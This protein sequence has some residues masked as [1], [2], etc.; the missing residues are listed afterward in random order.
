MSSTLASRWAAA[1]S[2][3]RASTSSVAESTAL[4]PICS[5]RDPPV[6]PPLGT[7]AVSDWTK[8]MSSSG[9]PSRSDTIMANAVAWP[10]P[11]ADVPTRMVAVPSRWISTE[12]NSLL[13]PPAV[14]STYTA[15]PMPEL[16]S[17]P[18][19]PPPGLLGSQLRRSRPGAPPRRGPSGSRRCRRSVPMTVCTGSTNAGS[20][21]RRRSSTGSICSSARG[22][23]DHPLQELGRLR[24]PGAPEGTHR[25]GVGH[26]HRDVVADGRDAVHPLGH[27]P[28]RTHGQR[29]SEAG[30]GAGVAQAPGSACPVMRPSASKPISIHCTW[31]R[32][33]GMATRFSER[34]STQARGRPSRPGG[35]DDGGVLV[36]HP[37][38]SAE[39]APDVRGDH[40][41]AACV[42][43]EGAADG[44]GEPVGH[45]GGHVDGQIVALAVVARN[46]GD[47]VA[48]HRHHRDPLVLQGGPH[49]GG[50]PG[51]R[52][53]LRRRRGCRRP[54][55]CRSPRTAAGRRRPRPAPGRPPPPA[56]SYSTSTSSAASRAAA[57]VSATTMATPSPTKRTLS[58]GQRR[59]GARRVQDH[60]AVEG[61][62]AEVGCGV[63][64]DDA[65]RGLGRA[66]RRSAPIRA[67]ATGERTKA[68]CARPSTRRLPT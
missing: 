51:Q 56:V 2:L 49:H 35:G 20:R 4:P 65:G 59:P 27:H 28:G 47:R 42:E 6:P 54:G 17:V 26:G 46:D 33:C 48:F 19:G 16:P 60:E 34:S 8:R 50:G 53:R 21:L 36:A 24:P 38:L 55:W 43:A 14:I 5:D 31:P 23:V 61:G 37:G 3:A 30:V 66:R 29:A 52:V 7:A 57:L 62:D 68:T 64:G 67:W 25:G 13:P 40:P 12:P 11:W 45:L 63:D 1:I 9:M 10:C 18:R 32:P 39:R 41:Q 58:V 44:A 22:Q 15:T